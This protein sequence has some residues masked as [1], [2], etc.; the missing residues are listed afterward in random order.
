MDM[1][2]V[3][4]QGAKPPFFRKDNDLVFV[5]LSEECIVID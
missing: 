4:E 5:A 2:M 3:P 1:D